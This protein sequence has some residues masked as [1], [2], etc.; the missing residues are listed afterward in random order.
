MK[1]NKNKMRNYKIFLSDIENSKSN[2]GN[3]LSL[4]N[5]CSSDYSTLVTSSNINNTKNS[6]IVRFSAQLP[7]IKNI[8]F[9]TI[10]ENTRDRLYL[11][12]KNIEYN[13]Y[14]T[15][16]KQNLHLI[17]KERKKAENIVTNLK[18]KIMEL[19]KEEQIV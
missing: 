17:R 19:Q 12:K 9:N 8:A 13:I 18:R 2:T 16:L 4:G 15:S 10:D 3:D 1:S 14:F 11:S 7:T 6:N 5:I